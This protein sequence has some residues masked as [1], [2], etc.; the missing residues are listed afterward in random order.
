MGAAVTDTTPTGPA[1]THPVQIHNFRAYWFSRL[2]MTLA[3]YAMILIIGWQVYNLAR[4][5]GM[6]M[7][8]RDP[9]AQ[10]KQDRRAQL[11]EVMEQAVQFFQRSKLPMDALKNIWIVADQPPTNYLDHAK[12]AVAVRLI[13]CI[14][15]GTR[16]INWYR[17]QESIYGNKFFRENLSIDD[18]INVLHPN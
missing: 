13:Q 4:E 1:P 2:A 14:Q 7:P 9:K 17:E 18:V 5:A 6:P 15:N 16:S 8:Q 11:A 12:F 3:Q 10:E